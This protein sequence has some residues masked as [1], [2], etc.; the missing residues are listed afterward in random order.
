VLVERR[1]LLFVALLLLGLRFGLVGIGLLRFGFAFLFLVGGSFRRVFV[2]NLHRLLDGFEHGLRPFI[3]ILCG[4]R[5]RFIVFG[6]G[7]RVRRIVFVFRGGRVRCGVLRENVGV[8]RGVV[9]LVV[10]R[11]RRFLGHV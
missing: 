2:R 4:G 9:V 11:G 5:V 7:R 3:F 6:C 8:N 1:L 10:V